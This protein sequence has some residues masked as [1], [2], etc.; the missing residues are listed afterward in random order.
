M[1]KT[2]MIMRGTTALESANA[3]FRRAQAPANAERL[4]TNIW[5]GVTA[6]R[7]T[8]RWLHRGRAFAVAPSSFALDIPHVAF[9][10]G[11]GICQRKAESSVSFSGA[12][13]CARARAGV[14]WRRAAGGGRCGGAWRRVAARGGA[15]PAI[16]CIC[17]SAIQRVS[18]LPAACK[19]SRVWRVLVAS[20]A[21]STL[22]RQHATAADIQQ[23]H[24]LLPAMGALLL[25]GRTFKPD[26]YLPPVR[27][28][29]GSHEKS[30]RPGHQAPRC[31]GDGDN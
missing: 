14:A 18:W 25:L 24:C 17:L 30:N 1:C 4:C 7:S 12:R 31:C 13:A 19:K 26:Q 11:E 5:D 9:S 8:R 27:Q 22:P 29:S 3:L 20:K 23:N 15:W 10:T 28:I 2:E 6:T 16:S 21:T